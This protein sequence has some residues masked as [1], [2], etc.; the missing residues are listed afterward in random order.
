MSNA[1]ATYGVT[2]FSLSPPS[3]GTQSDRE[4]HDEEG[5]KSEVDDLDDFSLAHETLPAQ[6]VTPGGLGVPQ[7]SIPPPPRGGRRYGREELR[8]PPPRQDSY[9]YSHP[10][11]GMITLPTLGFN[12]HG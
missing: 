7:V 4:R 5:V 12:Y 6:Q 11:L 10:G 9:T 1:E 8:S 2:P 3:K